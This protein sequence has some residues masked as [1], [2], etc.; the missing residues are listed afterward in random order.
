MNVNAPFLT[1]LPVSGR[2]SPGGD[3]RHFVD[4]NKMVILIKNLDKSRHWDGI[5]KLSTR[6][7]RPLAVGP[8]NYPERE[9]SPW[10]FFISGRLPANLSVRGDL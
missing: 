7:I 5:M 9:P 6:Y 8:L 3:R 2:K 4:A 1:M 10:G